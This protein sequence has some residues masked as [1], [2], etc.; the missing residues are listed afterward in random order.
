MTDVFKVWKFEMYIKDRRPRAITEF[1]SLLLTQRYSLAQ[2]LYYLG[3][4]LR[5]RQIVN[6]QFG[7]FDLV[8]RDRISWGSIDHTRI[9]GVVPTQVGV[10]GMMMLCEYVLTASS[11]ITLRVC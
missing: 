8:D 11:N 9:Q 5:Q 2:I 10:H 6:T 3:S 7:D 4:C 1:F